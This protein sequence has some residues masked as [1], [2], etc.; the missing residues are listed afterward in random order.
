MQGSTKRPTATPDTPRERDPSVTNFR[1]AMMLVAA[2]LT[3]AVAYVLRSVLVPLFF[4]FLV[5]YA[6]DPLVDRLEELKVPRTVGALLVMIG[7]AGLSLTIVFFAVPHFVDEMRAAAADFPSQL[8]SLETRVEPWLWSTLKIKLPH[9][10]SELVKA[11]GDKF[12]SELP[13]TLNAAALAL[14][15]TLSY[16][17]VA[18]SA[19]IVPVFAL[20]LLIDF[21]RI[22][23]KAGELVPRRYAPPVKEVARQIH[24]TLGSWVRGQL[25]A[26]MLLGALYAAGLRTVDIRLAVPIGV[27]TGMLAFVPYIGFAVGLSLAVGMAML[28]WQGLGTL[29]GVVL[30]MGGVQLLD[31][32]VITPRI[33]GRS[34]GL[35]PLET[36][37]TMMAAASLFGFFGV[38]LAVPLGAVIKIIIRRGVKGY[39]ASDF[40]SRPED[41]PRPMV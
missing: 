5:A 2:L 8:A 33:V 39:L 36:L 32:L 7:I 4:A 30:V 26:N 17:A 23:A 15:G 14:F 1:R 28:D 6:L 11:L 35:T 29:V 3:I 20:Y 27:L 41:S 38:L 19:L 9:T 21:D 40:Y 18:L 37:V 13:S 34:V 16:V 10:M 22:V 24:R 31:G 12:Q 25:T